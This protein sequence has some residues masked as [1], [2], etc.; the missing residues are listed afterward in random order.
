MIIAPIPITVAGI[1]IISLTT[2][3]APIPLWPGG[4]PHRADLLLRGIA[5]CLLLL[6]G[7]AAL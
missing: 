5:P 2:L 7:R 1:S 6:R 3:I 4:V